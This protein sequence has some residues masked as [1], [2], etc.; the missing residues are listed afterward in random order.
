MTARALLPASLSLTAPRWLPLARSPATDFT[1]MLLMLQ[2]ARTIRQLDREPARWTACLM[3]VEEALD[4]LHREDFSS[5]RGQFTSKPSQFFS[6]PT[7]SCP[8]ASIFPQ[9]C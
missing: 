8:A 5:L 4:T 2:T 9:A 3:A 6:S 7:L 1:M